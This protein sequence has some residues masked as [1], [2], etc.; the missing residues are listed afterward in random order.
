MSMSAPQ[1]EMRRALAG[2]LGAGKLNLAGRRRNSPRLQENQGQTTEIYVVK[3]EAELS[4]H[5]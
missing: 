1:D 3:G 5:G 4:G 2:E